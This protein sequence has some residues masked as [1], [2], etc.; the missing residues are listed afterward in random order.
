MTITEPTHA[1]NPQKLRLRR[2]VRSWRF[3]VG[4]ALVAALAVGWS[5]TAYNYT[6]SKENAASVVELV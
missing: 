2:S 4:V 6:V 3:W 1:R 5:L